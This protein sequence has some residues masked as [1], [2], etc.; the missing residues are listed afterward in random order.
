MTN[1][2]ETYTIE[3]QYGTKLLINETYN[4]LRDAH[5]KLKKLMKIWQT[6]T[7]NPEMLSCRIVV[8]FK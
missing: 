2:N 6:I 4:K 7:T 8:N 3:I 5:R 1:E